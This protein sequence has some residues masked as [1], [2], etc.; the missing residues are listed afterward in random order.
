[1]GRGTLEEVRGQ[2]SSFHQALLWESNSDL[3][4][5]VVNS[6]GVQAVYLGLCVLQ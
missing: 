5:W 3:Q 2:F 4:A 6:F 1:V